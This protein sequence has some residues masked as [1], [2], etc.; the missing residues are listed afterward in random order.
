MA[1]RRTGWTEE[2]IERYIK[3]GRGQGS[4]LDYKPWLTI[5]DVPSEGLAT[6]EKGWKTNRIH[7]FMSNLERSYFYICEW[8]DYVTDIR[9]HFPLYRDLTYEISEQ[10]GINHPIDPVNKVP[11]VMTTDFL[12]TVKKQGKT[13]TLART[14]I[15][16]EA[17]EDKRK[18]EK[19]EIERTYWEHQEIDWGIVTEKQFNKEFT[20]NMEWIHQSYYYHGEFTS[21]SLTSLS[22]E[23]KKRIRQEN[24]SVIEVLSEMDLELHLDDGMSLGILKYLIAHKEIGIDISKRFQT[25]HYIGDSIKSVQD[26]RLVVIT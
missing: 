21:S 6:R 2:K 20:R 25:H 26:K 10:I 1:K 24:R 3:E 23:L 13:E 18:L 22:S 12:I 14:I 15:P 16:S 19:L 11:T 9:E 4:G 7:H 8:S 5:Q 17:L